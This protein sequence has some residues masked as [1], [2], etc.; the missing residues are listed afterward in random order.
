MDGD[1]KE[2]DQLI[3]ELDQARQT[4][5]ELEIT[6]SKGKQ[7]ETAIH[8]EAEIYLAHFSLANDVL[9]YVDTHFRF[10]SVSPSVE[11]ALG[12]K[13]EE[14]IGKTF[15][16]LNL[17]H[18]DDLGRAVTD[19]MQVISG[20][21]LSSSIYRIFTKDRG[22]KFGDVRAVPFI[23]QGQVIGVIAVA[24]DITKRM[25]IEEELKK[26]REHLED[27][28]RERTAELMKTNELLNKEIEER[29]H[30]EIALKQSELHLRGMT[31]NL[32]AAVYQFYARDSGEV[33][34]HHV[35]GRTLE[36]LG[37]ESDPKDFFQRFTA[38]VAPEEREAFLSSI[39][40]AVRTASRWDYEVRFIRPTGEEIYIRGISRPE[41]R[42]HEIVFNGVML[43]ITDRKQ[44]EQELKKHRE[45]LEDL[46]RERTA[47]LSDAYEQLRHENEIR[48]TT[49][50]ALRSRELELERRRHELEEMNF[51]LKVLL[52][53]REDDK[54]GIENNIISNIKLS[55]LP[56]IEKLEVSGL[57]ESQKT[58]L[59]MMKSRLKDIASPFIHR[60]SSEYL[61]LTPNEIQVAS[62]IKE[63]K[64]SKDIA[65][66]LHISLNTVHSYR[67]NIRRRTGLKNKRVNLRSYL[68]T[69]E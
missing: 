49:E 19:T 13:P 43:D 44:I 35:G 56:C 20:E 51:A 5:A 14:L 10:V 42:E 57:G 6:V 50:T 27:L 29:T 16:D 36:F 54:A 45:Q 24:R 38:C 40:E 62:L 8:E 67:Y 9:Y 28:V 68:Q 26:H 58:Q 46:V 12:Y 30:V 39:Q 41:Q 25:E 53:Q 61:K 15:A 7:A 37:L 21:R 2:K 34:L 63:G 55:V 4:I 22:I 47:E 65:R 64:N 59:T 31:D 18:P 17:L 66:L 3:K 52:K 60:I 1:Q 32:P 11:N 69:L 33:G 23:R 48:K